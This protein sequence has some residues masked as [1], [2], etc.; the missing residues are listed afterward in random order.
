MLAKLPMMSALV[1]YRTELRVPTKRPKALFCSQIYA[2]RARIC[3]AEIPRDV[4]RTPQSSEPSGAG[5][6]RVVK[7]ELAET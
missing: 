2:G 3:Q 5:R 4:T 6:Y 1:V 7:Q